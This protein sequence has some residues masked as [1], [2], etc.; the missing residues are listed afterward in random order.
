MSVPSTAGQ[1]ITLTDLATDP[2]P[3]LA[4]LRADAPA[5][6]VPVLGAWL[7]TGYSL[8]VQ[9][10]R[11]AKTFTVDD[12]RFSTAK[13]VGASMLSLESGRMP[14]TGARSARRSARR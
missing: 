14:A 6:W 9:V 13:V 2:H 8:A 10:L 7:V 3:A 12:P 11:D 4:R 5:A 1:T